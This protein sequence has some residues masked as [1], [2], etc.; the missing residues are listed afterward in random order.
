MAHYGGD[1]NN[2]P[3]DSTCE[4]LTISKASPTI[5]TQASPQTGTVGVNI[6]S[7]SDTATF[8]G[9]VSGFAPTGSVTF[10]LYSDAACKTAVSGVSGSGAISTTGGVSTATYSTS[11]TP[12]AAGTYYW[13]ASYAGDV[14]NSPF[15]TTCGASTE[16]ISVGKASPTIT[17]QASPTT[18]TSGV[19]LLVSD[20][21]T[22]GNTT[23]VAPTGTVSFTLFSD[24]ACTTAVSGVSGSGGISTTGGVSTATYSTTWTPPGAG[25]YTWIAS[26]G[27]DSNNNGFTTKCTDPNE[28]IVVGKAS[29][30]ITTQANP[31]GATSGT[32]LTVGDTATFGNTTTVTPTG[33]VTF[34]LYS[35]ATCGTAVTGVSGSGTISTTGGVS[36]ASYSTTWTPPGAGTYTWIASYAGDSNNNAFTTKCTDPNEQIVV[37]KAS[38]SITTQASP[39][40]G[41]V[42]LAITPVSDRATFHSTTT[43]LPTG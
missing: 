20:T 10:T 33:S 29:P 15:T 23:T 25:T 8:N 28:Q 7:L 11:W 31:T 37:A 30:N 21:A 12:P 43:V 9:T 6:P 19:S 35:G 27:G 34:T 16:Q 2:Q 3:A 36:T 39:T 4:P 1:T 18:G 5:T 14:N 41:T 22:F 42:G 40:T 24:A 13:I 38:P 32:S 26:Y 17:T